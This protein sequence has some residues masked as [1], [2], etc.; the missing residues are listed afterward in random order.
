MVSAF[1][2][3]IEPLPGQLSK[4][5]CRTFSQQSG[6]LTTC[7]TFQRGLPLS[8][9]DRHLFHLIGEDLDIDI[10]GAWDP[11]FSFS[12][13][14]AGGGFRLRRCRSRRCGA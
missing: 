4:M 5:A 13:P 11:D 8:Q 1:Q 3:M 2:D 10:E 12:G 6:L 14:L 9:K 7:M